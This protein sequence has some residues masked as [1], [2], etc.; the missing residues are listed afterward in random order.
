MNK[1][2]IID[3]GVLLEENS[4]AELEKKNSKYILLQVSDVPQ[5]SL[6]LVQKF[7]VKDYSVQRTPWICCI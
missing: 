6:I 2:L 1:V 3:D 7:C 4:M 5:A